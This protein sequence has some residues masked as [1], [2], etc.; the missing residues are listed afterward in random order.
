MVMDNN[1]LMNQI[2]INQS[3]KRERPL[4][5][6]HELNSSLS[7]SHHHRI[8]VG[9]VLILVR[10]LFGLMFDVD[11]QKK[12]SIGIEKRMAKLTCRSQGVTLP[13]CVD[14]SPFVKQH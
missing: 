2:G 4:S 6:S 5:N 3:K 11:P 1:Y 13:H 8:N 7:S 9:S 12:S 14:L 10:A